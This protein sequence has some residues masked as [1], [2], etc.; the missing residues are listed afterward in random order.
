[1]PTRQFRVKYPISDE[2]KAALGKYPAIASLIQL[3]SQEFSELEIVRLLDNQHYAHIRELTALIEENLSFAGEIGEKI[4]KCRDQFQFSQAISEMYLLNYLRQ[5]LGSDVYAAIF[6][7]GQPGWDITADIDGHEIRIEVYTPVELAGHRLFETLLRSILKYLDLTVGYTLD[8]KVGIQ[9]S[10][11]GYN[12]RDLYYVYDTGNMEEVNQWLHSFHKT[13]KSW[14]YCKSILGKKN[15][16][17]T[18]AGPGN[19]LKVTI[20]TKK[21]ARDPRERQIVIGHPTKS[22]DTQL[23]FRNGNPETIARN[24]WGRKIRQKVFRQQCGQPSQNWTRILVLNF[25]LADSGW[26][27]FI[28]SDW[29][30]TNFG[31]L[32]S[33]LAGDN[34]PFDVVIPAQLGIDCCFGKPAW[35]SNYQGENRNFI[36]KVAM[37]RQCEPPSSGQQDEIDNFLQS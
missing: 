21:W 6:E 9:R 29:F 22:S 36:A 1:M 18:I 5:I 4:L 34:Q 13:V 25:M 3:S 14:L 10:G 28:S 16:Q 15:N 7:K 11:L 37:K 20:D 24:E 2:V 32:I 31:N 12:Q 35:I 27:E 33:Y 17:L 23:F 26:P 30:T 8:V 19:K